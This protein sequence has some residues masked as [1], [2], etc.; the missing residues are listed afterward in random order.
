[1]TD[2]ADAVLPLIRTR[3]DI[4]RWSASNAHG[5]QMHEAVNILEAAEGSADPA[6]L[7]DVTQR[8]L[9]SALKVIMRADD[10]SG[11]IGDACR[12]LIDQHARAAVL[13]QPPTAKLVRWMIRFQFEEECDFFHLDPVDYAP[14]LGDTGMRAYRRELDAIRARLGSR[15]ARSAGW[16]GP[17]AHEWFVLD[18]LD[19]RLAVHDR[20]P[21]AVIRTHARDEAVPAWL[22]DTAHALAEI[23][24]IDLAI[25][26]ARRATDHP[27][28]GHQA[29]KAAAYWCELLSTHRP[30]ELMAARLHIFRRWPTSSHATDVHADSGKSWPDHEVEVQA[31]LSRDPREAVSF[32]LRTLRDAP[33]AW[34]LAHDLALDDNSLWLDLARAYETIDPGATLPVYTQVVLDRLVRADA[35][36]Y[37]D[38][39]KMLA[40]MRKLTAGTSRSG[41]VD[42]LV[43]D[44]RDEHRNRPR[45]Q[46]EF[47]R[48]GLP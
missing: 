42:E 31:L 6:D 13:A 18:D 23:D 16:S 48:A 14:A 39:A 34:E 29:I 46:Q 47:T 1:M 30:D 7:L 12:R 8:A 19:Q 22:D 24:E 40:H 10:S 4:H 20:D 2:L 26:W 17:H 9:A 38:A 11:I 25:E 41:D 27:S 37:R 43:A 5:A 15:P 44:L 33:F 21:D 28:S 35:R 45:L 3:S 32:A 36:G